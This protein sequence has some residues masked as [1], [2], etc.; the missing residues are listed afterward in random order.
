VL[1]VTNPTVRLSDAQAEGGLIHTK[2]CGSETICFGSGSG[3]LRSLVPYPVPY[4]SLLYVHVLFLH[5]ND[6]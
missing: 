5:A 2:S 6:F 1:S 3:F 4:S